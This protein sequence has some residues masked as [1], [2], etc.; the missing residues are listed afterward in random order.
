V[1]GEPHYVL[2]RRRYIYKVPKVQ[3]LSFFVTY[4]TTSIMLLIFSYTFILGMYI[5]LDYSFEN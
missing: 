2:K 5:G 3:V 1:D 4:G